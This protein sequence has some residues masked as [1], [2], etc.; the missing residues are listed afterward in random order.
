MAEE[1]LRDRIERTRGDDG[2]IARP[3]RDLDFALGGRQAQLH[4]AMILEGV[5]DAVLLEDY[6]RVGQRTTVATSA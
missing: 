5:R 4:A 1:L 6:T 2:Q 3:T